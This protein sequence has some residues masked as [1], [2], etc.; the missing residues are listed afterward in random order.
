MSINSLTKRNHYLDL[1]LV[2]IMICFYVMG[3]IEMVGIAS[4]YIKVT[5]HI[6][7]AKANFLPSLVYIW[8]IIITIPAGIL[9][10]KIGRER[11]VILSMSVMALS[12]IVPIFGSSYGLMILC[13]AILGMSNV[14]MQT[15]LYPLLSNIVS[16]KKLS[17][18]LTMGQ[19]IK[20]LSSFS[21][22]YIAMLG[23]LYFI[24]TT[25]LGWRILFVFYLIIT[26][27]TIIL[28][29]FSKF[30]KKPDLEKTA[31]YKECFRLLK[32]PFVLFAFIGV[33]C[34][35][36]ID[37][38]T[39]TVTPKI[40]MERLGMSIEKASFGAS[41]YFI[42]R[43]A[44]CLFWTIFIRKVANKTFFFISAFLILASLIGLYFADTK[45][46]IYLCIVMI[47]L[48]NA[49]LF[50]VLFSQAVLSVPQNKDTI[51][52]LMI[53]G[54]AGGALF[55][56][57]MG[58]VFDKVGLNGS[59]SVLMVGVIYLIFYCFQLKK[60]LPTNDKTA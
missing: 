16:G 51:S 17:T 43:L 39:N 27:L 45:P 2:S 5:L 7:D 52:V 59:L 23:A 48:G 29:N 9:M 6:N 37:I 46:T 55:P 38:S 42:S 12:M 13:F 22:P 47:G 41:L 58:V 56:Y 36:G 53:M 20:T 26:I 21:A 25:G 32:V 4:N 1:Q 11:T 15:S 28:M 60:D 8:F 30:E 10:H 31:T 44:G 24:K 40:L 33:M 34:H 3:S 57:T 49:N 50:P 54:Q 14:C 18:D 35:V 19:F